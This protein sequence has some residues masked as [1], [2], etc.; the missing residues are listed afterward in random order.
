MLKFPASIQETHVAILIDASDSMLGR[1]EGVIKQLNALVDGLQKGAQKNNQKILASIYSFSSTTECLVRDM[2]INKVPVFSKRDYTTHGM[3]AMIDAIF[4]AIQEDAATYV[5]RVTDRAHIVTVITDG[6]DN[7]S[8]NTFSELNSKIAELTATDKWTFSFLVPRGLTSYI[9]R[10][11]PSVPSGNISEWEISHKGMEAATSQL[12]NSYAAYLNL[13]STGATSSKGFFTANV[14]A[15]AATQAKKKLDDVRKDFK[16]MTVRTQDPKSLQDFVESRGLIFRKG[17]SFYQLT[18]PETVQNHK[19][20][21]LREIA[22]GAIYG[23]R[24]ARS[25]LGLPDHDTKVKPADFSDWDIFVQSTSNNRKLVV[26]TNL[27]YLK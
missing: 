12:S 11:L 18:K 8:A 21:L 4:T 10:E 19:E 26:G 22:T 17:Y 24:D 27:L 9:V 7:A 6:Q 1:A 25:I 23:G 20:V 16:E 3:T 14:N 5:P 2:N 13:R 15:K